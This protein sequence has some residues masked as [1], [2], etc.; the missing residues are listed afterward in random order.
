[1]TR[2]CTCDDCA[3]P[4]ERMYTGAEVN[5]MMDEWQKLSLTTLLKSL[6]GHQRQRRG[7]A[8][9][10]GQRMTVPVI[11]AQGEVIGLQVAIDAIKR[12]LR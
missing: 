7:S 6:E 3:R 8:G 2:K 9:Q 5:R 11:R 10:P 1:M 12:R 4:G